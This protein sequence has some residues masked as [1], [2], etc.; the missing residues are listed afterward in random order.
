VT[1]S[2]ATNSRPTWASAPPP[3][4]PRHGESMEEAVERDAA[5]LVA[6]FRAL[7]ELGRYADRID[8]AAEPAA[9]R[10]AALAALE[11]AGEFAASLADAWRRRFPAWRAA[12]DFAAAIV[13][14]DDGD[15][16]E[17]DLPCRIGPPADDGEGRYELRAR[18][19]GGAS[20][21]VFR[22]IDRVLSA[23]GAEV[24][25]AVKLVPCP[26]AEV[27]E[28]L[29]EAGAAR[30]VSHDGIARVLDAGAVDSGSV[31]VPATGQAAIYLV[32]EFIEGVPLWAWRAC[33]PE[34]DGEDCRRL[35]EGVRTA[36]AACHAR[37]VAHGDLSPANVLV[38]PDGRTR[39]VDFGR[40]TWR[41][42]DA[43]AA[44]ASDLAR[45]DLL[46]EWL[47][48]D[49]PRA[50]RGRPATRRRRV[51][52]V[53]LALVTAIAVGWVAGR[54]NARLDAAAATL[55]GASF[56]EGPRRSD[57]DLVRMLLRDG[58]VPAAKSLAARNRR[59]LLAIEAS[60]A[61]RDGR[62]DPGLELLVATAYLATGAYP[63]TLAY[64]ERATRDGADEDRLAYARALWT[65]AHRWGASLDPDER[66][67]VEAA[68]ERCGAPGLLRYPS[69]GPDGGD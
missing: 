1:A 68:A 42:E 38:A 32:Q 15:D 24:P 59:D 65:L 23:C 47:E 27:A 29:R 54:P 5:A 67:E 7:P 52:L 62:P 16:D 31:A 26:P 35:L 39:V 9:A 44:I 14:L 37:G 66:A 17:T 51:G 60:D 21:T 10:A 63:W 36:I 45:L 6:R 4:A 41:G 3:F 64:A 33:H 46:L 30:S 57:R 22:A 43:A 25:V 56:V 12:I 8:P 13:A 40:A 11:V 50:R 19:G 55:F 58:P 28:R 2:P 53:A 48:R 69:F 20:G 18:L 49:L 61:R 34:R